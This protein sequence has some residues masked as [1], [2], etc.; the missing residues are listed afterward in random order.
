MQARTV[1]LSKLLGIYCILMGLFMATHSERAWEDVTA[2]SQDQA[3][4]FITAILVIFAGVAMVLLHNRW[5]GG[6]T[7]VV[8]TLLGWAAL[9][10]GLVLL[11]ASPVLIANFY[12]YAIHY[13]WVMYVDAGIALALGVYLSVMGFR[14][15]AAEK[16]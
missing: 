5:S 1:F 2:F 9:G 14:G 11:F 15:S 13:I 8:V 3:L 7:T 10:K 12:M 6:A 16:A 4:V